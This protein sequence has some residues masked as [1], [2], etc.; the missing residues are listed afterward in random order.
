M[1][2]GPQ[3]VSCVVLDLDDTIFLERDYVKSGFDAV[4]A[5]LDERDGIAG[6]AAAAWSRFEEGHR[7]NTFDVV[8]AE[9]GVSP[10]AELVTRLVEVYRAHDPTIEML[11]DARA[12]IDRL[13]TRTTLAVITDGPLE[14]QRAKARAMGVH[15]WSEVIVYTSELGDGFAKPHVR[16]FELVESTTGACGAA[17]AYLA[18]NPLKDFVAPRTLGWHTVRVRRAE[19]L[20]AAVGSGA[21]V[22][23]EVSD[24]SMALTELQSRGL[25]T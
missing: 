7:G 13:R 9:L 10:S 4:G 17:C 24:L 5:Y 12:A 14:S 23:A 3:R 20:H 16:A 21:D 19:S 8:L 2:D 15:E 25:A 6:F 11:P 1:N 22:D 18:D